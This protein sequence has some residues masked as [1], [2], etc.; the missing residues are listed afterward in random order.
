MPKEFGWTASVEIGYPENVVLHQGI[1]AA[2]CG[3]LVERCPVYEHRDGDLYGLSFAVDGTTEEDARL[4]SETV[5]TG[6]LANIGLGWIEVHG[7]SVASNAEIDSFLDTIDDGINPNPE[8]RIR[9][10]GQ[11]VYKEKPKNKK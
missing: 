7:L 5:L 8:E 9:L 3:E 10:L 1:P 6:A 11:L 4:E 2:I